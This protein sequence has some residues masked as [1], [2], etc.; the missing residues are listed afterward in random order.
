MFFKPVIFSDA[1]DRLQPHD[2]ICLIYETV[3]ELVS[4]VIPFISKG[5]KKNEK[6]IYIKN[7]L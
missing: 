3:E 2:H 7:S 5:L 1:L 6:C 4:V